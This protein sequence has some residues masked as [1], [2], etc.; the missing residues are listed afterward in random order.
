MGQNSTAIAVHGGAFDIPPADKDRFRVGCLAAAQA[1]WRELE[2]GGSA[3][4][5]VEVAVRHL[6]A[7]GI[8]SAGRGS[9]LSEEGFIELENLPEA[10]SELLD[11]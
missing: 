4:D 10:V 8:F 2:G 6:E 7:S 5:A 1:G 9:A 3:L 11:V